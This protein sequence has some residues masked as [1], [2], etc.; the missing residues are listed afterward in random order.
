MVSWP[1]GREVQGMLHKHFYWNHN[2]YN[3]N[4]RLST[5][6]P[7]Y[8]PIHPSVLSTY[9]IFLSVQDK[10]NRSQRQNVNYPFAPFLRR[11]L[12]EEYPFE[13]LQQ[14][15]KNVQHFGPKLSYTAEW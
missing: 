4:L 15:Q 8:C 10:L 13:I 1:N 11:M 7:Y 12:V 2:E 14:Q 6:F 9:I 5:R 3:L